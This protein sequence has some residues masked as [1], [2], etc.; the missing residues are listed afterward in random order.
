LARRSIACVERGDEAQTAA[1]K[2]TAYREGE[3]FARQAIALD[4][5]SAEAHFAL[6]ARSGRLLLTSSAVVGPFSVGRTTREFDRALELDPNYAEALAARGAL[7]RQLPRL[8]GGNTEKA[9]WYLTRTIE[10]DPNAVVARIELAKIYSDEGD[11]QGSVA[12]LET[13]A[14]IAAR[15]G[16]CRSFAKARVLL[17][18]LAKAT[19]GW[20]PRDAGICR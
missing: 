14:G 15:E 7:Y 6:F 19:P 3:A 5:R 8:L 11:A 13:A 4:D 9:E 20:A 18:E 1:A 17:H 12:L 16:K 2:L 10:L